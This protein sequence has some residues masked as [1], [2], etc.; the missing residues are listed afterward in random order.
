MI[1]ARASSVLPGRKRARLKPEERPVYVQRRIVPS[2]EIRFPL[3]PST[4]S[5]YFNVAGGRRKTPRYRAWRQQAALLIDVQRPGRMAG[6]C[7]VTIYLPPFS[8]DADNRIKPCLDAAVAAGVLADDGQRYVRR[9]LVEVDRAATE[10]RMV[11]TMPSVE[12]QDRAEIE[13]RSREGQ[14]A[15]H[16]AVSLGLDVGHVRTVLAEIRP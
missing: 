3:P 5:L 9:A 14:S 11:L 13:V 1:A 2:V 10:V 7:D 12:E 4:N 16:I 6:P 8:G 15:A